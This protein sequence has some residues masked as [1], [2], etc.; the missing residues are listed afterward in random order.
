MEQKNTITIRGRILSYYPRHLTNDGS[1]PRLDIPAARENLSLFKSIAENH[2]IP[3]VL[4]Y[5]TLLGAVREQSFLTHDSD[6]D[7]TIDSKYEYMLLEIIPELEKAGLL[8]IRYIKQTVF[9]KGVILY[10]FM[11][12]EMWIDVY[13]MQKAF[14][15]YVIMGKKYPRKFFD[16]FD[17]LSFYNQEY[18]VPHNPTGFLAL[19][20]GEDWQTPKPGCHSSPVKFLL[21]LR[22][23]TIIYSRT[24]SFIKKTWRFAKRLAGKWR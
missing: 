10:S 11:R 1:E 6:T 20:Y 22:L 19:V 7:I 23:I 21:R 18:S 15:G 12:N 3:I 24:P 2:H 17:S 13:I 9:N 14:N 8:F 4:M 16:K 5:G